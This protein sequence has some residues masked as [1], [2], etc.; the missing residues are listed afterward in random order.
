M[1][2][3]P[4]TLN[5][6]FV[7]AAGFSRSFSEVPLQFNLAAYIRSPKVQRVRRPPTRIRSKQNGRFLDCPEQAGLCGDRHIHSTRPQPRGEQ[8]IAD[9]IEMKDESKMDRHTVATDTH[10][11]LMGSG[12]KHTSD[13]ARTSCRCSAASTTGSFYKQ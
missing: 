4:R 5:K 11:P 8:R 9:F 1:A 3:R 2:T 12:M 13:M 7:R 6:Q 10:R